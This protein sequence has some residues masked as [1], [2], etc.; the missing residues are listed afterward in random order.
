MARSFTR[1]QLLGTAAALGGAAVAGT[2]TSPA[3]AAGAPW[4]DTIATPPG[5][6]PEG[7]AIGPGGVAYTGSLID[8]S[9]YGAELATGRGR[10]ISEGQGRM[11]V[12]LKVDPYGRLLVAGGDSGE[13]RVVGR[14]DGRLL[15]S[16]RAATGTV[17]VNDVVVGCGGA[18]FTDSFN[19]VLHH[20]PLRAGLPAASPLR[21]LP[22]TGAWAPTPP[23]GEYWGANG[24]ELTPDGRALL[25][26][27]D[28]VSLL[29]RVDPR[30][31]QATEVALDGGSVSN[32]DGL[33]LHG[34]MLYVVR[35]WSYAVDVFRLSDDGTRSS[36]A[37]R[38]TDPRFDEPTTAA[39]HAGRLYVVNARFDADWSDPSTSST[40][41]SVPL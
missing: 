18:W 23:G 38:I 32:G 9:I 20:L 36:F 8:G 16:W 7:I 6:Q 1:R 31:G 29:Y 12:G 19:D 17:F 11:S 22:L 21:R 25:V 27:N 5:F 41:V 24:I 10:I 39:V 37:K 2:S 35:N 4:P 26:V 33:V 15:A 13:I 34:R 14:R 40:V 28:N 3:R 30:T